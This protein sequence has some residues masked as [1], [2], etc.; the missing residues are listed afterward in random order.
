MNKNMNFQEKME[1]VLK[2]VS[3]PA[4]VNDYI[5]KEFLTDDGD[6]D[7]FLNIEKREDLFDTRTVDQQKD[8]AFEVYDFIEEKTA[9]LSSDMK[10]HL[11]ITGMYLSPR[12]QEL[13]RHIL[14]EHY[15]IEL[16]KVQR[17]YIKYRN[18]I[19]TLI[20]FGIL[21]FLIYSLLFFLT[22]F[23]FLLEVLGFMFT[24]ALWEALDIYISDLND[25]KSERI[26]I[27]QNLL[28]EVDFEHKERDVL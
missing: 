14:R 18:R 6:A 19:I 8:L 17:P 27:T 15:A 28:L 1:E 25:V 21:I 26:E 12:E 10:I 20:L 16:N 23:T 11:H 4:Y 3:T 13:V 5:K 7:L 9:I 22:N 24:F 2:K